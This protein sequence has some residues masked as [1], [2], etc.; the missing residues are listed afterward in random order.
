MIEGKTKSGFKF[1]IDER[2][3]TDYRILEFVDE[4]DKAD[5]IGKMRII[6]SLTDFLLGTKGFEKLEKHI[7]SKNEGFCSISNL[8][9]ELYEIMS[10]TKEIKNS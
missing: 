10:N 6:P 2:C 3:L 8:Q 5:D 1:K 9:T 7:R 4:Y